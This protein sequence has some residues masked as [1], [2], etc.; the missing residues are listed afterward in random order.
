L[1]KDELLSA[2]TKQ[3]SRLPSHDGD[4]RVVLLQ[5]V[6]HR[7]QIPRCVLESFD[8]FAQL[9]LLGLLAAYHFVYILQE[10]T[11]CLDFNHAIGGKQRRLY[12]Q[13]YLGKGLNWAVF[14]SDW[15]LL[16]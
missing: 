11:P 12:P 6:L 9:G 4:W 14:G 2:D 8:L 5:Q 1:S 15:P 13:D 3:T 16:N 10:K 7:F